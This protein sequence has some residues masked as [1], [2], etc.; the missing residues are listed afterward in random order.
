[1]T[2]KPVSLPTLWWAQHGIRLDRVSIEVYEAF[3]AAGIPSILLKGPS[4]ASW[5]YQEHELRSYGDSD[6]LVRIQDWDAAGE[7]LVSLGF[8]PQW[9][10]MA[11]PNLGAYDS[12]AF[13]RNGVDTVDLH[14]T[15]RGL[16]AQCDTVWRVLSAA[17]ATHRVLYAD[18]PV[19]ALPARAMHL[20]LHAAQ[21][22]GHEG[23]PTRDLQRGLEILPA[24]LWREAMAVAAA[25]DGLD[26]FGFGLRRLPRGQDLARELGLPERVSIETRLREGA[27]P[28]AHGL[29]ALARLPG[30]RAKL[31]VL[32]GELFPRPSFMRWWSPLAR[33]GRR[34]LVASYVWRP[35]WLAGRLPAAAR[36]IVRA[37]RTRRGRRYIHPAAH[38][39]RPAERA[40][41]RRRRRGRRARR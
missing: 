28:L 25:L 18:L 35:L 31:A 30:A 39:G 3:E 2:S 32:T 14:A 12:F 24:E 23:N 19:L 15:L 33:R 7:V 5:L 26:A 10:D 22:W 27:V 16:R 11:H 37:W 9:G 17:P 6:L 8:Q 41:A 21:H 13:K 40:T 38:P 29:Y 34:G 1:M 4:I 36:E 20:A